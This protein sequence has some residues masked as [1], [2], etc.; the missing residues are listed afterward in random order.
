MNINLAEICGIIV[1]DGHLNRYVSPKRSNYKISV[2]GHKIDDKD[3]FYMIQK[4]FYIEF[5]KKPVLKNRERCIELRVNS[6]NILHNLE[7]IGIPVGNKSGIVFIPTEIKDNLSLS[8]AFIRGL[9]DTDFSVVFKLRKTKKAYPRI[10]ADMK[11]KILLEDVCKVLKKLGIKYCGPYHR[12]RERKGSFY[13]SY[14]IDI[15]G[16]N[17]FSIWMDKIGLRN[18]KH[19]KKIREF[20]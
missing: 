12:K 6:K 2:F 3:Y 8:T 19:L 20:G 10:T 18:E 16:H 13:E 7:R 11:S 17:N 1:G 4:L 5:G 15:N 14:L 9:A